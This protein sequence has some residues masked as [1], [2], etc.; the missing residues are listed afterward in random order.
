MYNP[1]WRRV[2]YILQEIPANLYWWDDYLVA[3]T[4]HSSHILGEFRVT[5]NKLTFLELE[6]SLHNDTVIIF[7]GRTV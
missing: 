4:P 1:S 2:H 7:I 3:T 6:L 5:L